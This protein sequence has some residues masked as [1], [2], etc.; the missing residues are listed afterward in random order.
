VTAERD[1]SYRNTWKYKRIV[2][3][4]KRVLPYAHLGAELYTNYKD[5]ENTFEK[6]R[7]KRKFLKTEEKRLKSKFEGKI[8]NL[9]VNDGIVLVKLIDRQTTYTSYEI[10]KELRGG[11][12]AFLWQGVARLFDSSLKHQ[13]NPNGE[14]W[15]IEEII[16]RINAGEI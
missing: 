1:R 9:T 15:M 4:V 5:Q 16:G 10:L 11:T 6:N 7:E 8:R 13:Y 14:D 3:R 12:S 2:K